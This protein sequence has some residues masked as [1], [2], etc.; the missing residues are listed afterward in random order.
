V[1][2][3]DPTAYRLYDFATRDL[4]LG[5][6][7]IGSLLTAILLVPYRARQRWA[8]FVLWILPAWAAAVP[9]LYLTYGTA[10]GRPPAPPMISGPIFAVVA[11]AVLL[12][13][14]ERF[15]PSSLRDAAAPRAD[16]GSVEV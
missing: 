16:E 11:T 5:L 14:R 15:F 2:A 12:L 3:D 7:V 4:G 1:Q 13:D 9:L 10:P 8:W 6:V